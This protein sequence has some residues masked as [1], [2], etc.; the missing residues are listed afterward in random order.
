[1]SEKLKLLTTSDIQR[2]CYLNYAQARKVLDFINTRATPSQPTQD[3]EAAVNEIVTWH[4]KS[5]SKSAFR[6]A[7]N[8]ILAS[9]LASKPDVVKVLEGVRKEITSSCFYNS[10][11]DAG[12]VAVIDTA[13]K[14]AK[15]G[16]QSPS[17]RKEDD[18]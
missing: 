6:G 4:E 2:A 18:G 3:V 7:M 5:H 17:K 9:L 12:K 11:D 13:I 1:M 16:E 14:Q 8:T 15:E 10:E